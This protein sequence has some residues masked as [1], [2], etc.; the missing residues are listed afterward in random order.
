MAAEAAVTEAPD[1]KASDRGTGGTAVREAGGLDDLMLAMDVVDTLRHREDW[2]SREID[3][4][5]READLMARLRKIY[6]GQGIQ[7]SDE[8]LAQGIRALNERRFVYAP[9]PPGLARSLA[10]LW[11]QRD[12]YFKTLAALAAL[13]LVLGAVY[14]QTSIRPYRQTASAL[15]TAHSEAV[16]AATG[17]AGRQR[18]DR[19]LAEAESALD[20]GDR[21]VA[22]DLVQ[23]LQA[24]QADLARD[25]RLR[26]ISAAFVVPPT[27]LHERV[28]Y[29]IVEAVAPDGAILPM[30]IR[31]GEGARTEEVTRWGVQVSRETYLTVDQD[32]RADGRIDDNELGVK[33]RGEP[34]VRFT[35]PV[36]GGTITRW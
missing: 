29:L 24:L 1:P 8:V 18:A 25:Y 21:A 28:H 32:L 16:A 9:P 2:I 31:N 36:L 19:L 14:Y 4:A 20:E 27:A 22:D 7:V 34:D 35:K 5:G 26:I 15:E 11:V 30:R 23:Q 13:L 12:R 33:A 17:E 10:L 3:E 6:A